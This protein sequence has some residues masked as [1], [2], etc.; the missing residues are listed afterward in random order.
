M[1]LNIVLL[2]MIICVG[3]FAGD[4]PNNGQMTVEELSIPIEARRNIAG[5]HTL[6]PFLD[7]R[8]VVMYG[9]FDGDGM[10]DLAVWV[11]NAQGKRGLWIRLS[12]QNESLVMGCGFRDVPWDDWKFDEWA[13]FRKWQPI[14]EPIPMKDSPPAP[15]PIGDYIVLSVKD[16]GDVS[17]YWDG[18]QIRAYSWE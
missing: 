15:H 17:I 11:V 16:A 18:R 12:S 13:L 10:P 7:M 1:K 8:S 14:N 2:S 6:K 5:L 3:L 9:D 4:R